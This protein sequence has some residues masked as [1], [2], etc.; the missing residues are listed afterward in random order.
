MTRRTAIAIAM[1][2]LALVTVPAAAQ[3][4]PER[5]AYSTESDLQNPDI[6]VLEDD[7][8]AKAA[9]GANVG[10]TTLSSSPERDTLPVWSP[11]GEMIA[12]TR[13]GFEAEKVVVTTVD[14]PAERIQVVGKCP[15][16]SPDSARLAFERDA[17]VVI[18]DFATATERILAP[19]ACPVWSPVGETILAVRDGSTLVAIDAI[20][21]AE[22]EVVVND[23]GS[24]EGQRWSPDGTRVAYAFTDARFTA[25]LAIVGALGGPPRTLAVLAGE[26]FGPI[27]WRPDGTQIAYN[28]EGSLAGAQ[29]K[30]LVISPDG[31]EPAVIADTPRRGDRLGDWNP[32]GTRLVFESYSANPASDPDLQSYIMVVEPGGQPFRVAAGSQPTFSP[33]GVSG[34][35][36]SP[37]PSA[38]PIPST[39]SG[40]DESALRVEHERGRPAMAASLQHPDEVSTS[41][42]D[43]VRS[44]LLLAALMMLV[45]FPSV[46]FNNTL[47]ENYDEV[48]GWFR[49]G[50]PARERERPL[51]ETWQ[52]FGIF[53]VLTVIL[54][55]FL[56]PSFGL[57]RAS[58][59]ASIAL[60]VCIVVLTFIFTVPSRRYMRARH[61]DSGR[62]KVLPGTLLVAL[63]CV[64]VSRVAGFQPGYFY[65]A[66]A[67]FA[68]AAELNRKEQG[69]H[70]ARAAIWM[71]VLS[72][73]AWVVRAPFAELATQQEPAL[74]V[75][76]V[77][78]ILAALFIG[79]IEGVVFG[80]IPL[81]FLAGEKLFRWSR[82][83]WAALFGL[84]GFMFLHVLADPNS[85]YLVSPNAAPMATIM[86]FFVVFGALSVAFWGY[87][88]FR[89]RTAA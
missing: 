9:S 51:S 41:P 73:G 61:S 44:L 23:R 31:G 57:D 20:S 69:V 85:D 5:I 76:I 22:R 2:G 8:V 16:W 48:R 38:P 66:I 56:D 75:L 60:T 29:T 67:G 77:D 6:F 3:T 12:F 52:G 15:T 70:A 87:F 49:F 30:V 81:R 45:I 33:I 50:R 35:L 54:Y 43:L 19:G 58:F 46:L 82:P 21:G 83:V 34:A 25:G 86:V 1:I 47:D 24:I 84:A 42:A 68:F 17:S 27:R 13:G 11:N 4:S 37:L 59:N 62:I 64:V 63:A 40:D 7:P 14:T 39:D 26:S 89:R 88:R 79:G 74:W 71:L 32:Q 80:M 28:T 78:S 55:G 53:T 18:H 65:G 36:Q 72:L 10:S